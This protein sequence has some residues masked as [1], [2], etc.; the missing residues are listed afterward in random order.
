MFTSHDSSYLHIR[1]S[2]LLKF[3]HVSH[4]EFST[5]SVS[6]SEVSGSHGKYKY[7][8]QHIELDPEDRKAFRAQWGAD[9]QNSRPDEAFFSTSFLAPSFHHIDQSITRSVNDDPDPQAIRWDRP[10]PSLAYKSRGHL[11]AITHRKYYALV[12]KATLP[13]DFIVALHG[14]KVLFVIRRYQIPGCAGDGEQLYLLIGACEV[15]AQT[16]WSEFEKYPELLEE[17]VLV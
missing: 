7:Q 1:G 9:A 10:G 12:P 2:F 5:R 4:H 8:G 3:S 14:I 15:D 17:I 11:V 6:Y 16:K 13:G